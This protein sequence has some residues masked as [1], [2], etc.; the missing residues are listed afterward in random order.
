MFRA[1]DKCELLCYNY[2]EKGSARRWERKNGSFGRLG[3]CNRMTAVKKKTINMTEGPLLG[4]IIVFFLPLMATN[5]LQTL[6]NAADMMVVGM[7]S[8]PDAVG[9]I[10]LTGAFVNL[11]LNVFMGFATGANVVVARFLGARDD[12]RASRA[13]HTAIS[14]SVLLGVVGT[15]IGLVVSRPVLTLMGAEG[16]LL[17][18]ATTYT[19]IYFAGAPF[20]ALTNY[21]IAIL[22][23]KGDT[24][25]PLYVL[26]LSGLANVLMNLFFVL[27]L[28]FSV[29]GVA[30]ATV[31]SNVLSAAL[32]LGKLSRD[33]GACR[34]SFRRLC[35][36]RPA[37]R[38]IIYIGLPAGVQGSLFS[39][40]NM[41]IQSSILQV[42]NMTVGTETA[43]A[44]IV[45]GNAAAGN[46]EG[47]AY[48]ATNSLYQAAITFTSQNVGAAKY[49]R[50]HK[51]MA[52]CYFLTFCVAVIFSGTLF[53]LRTPL[54]ALYDVHPDVVGSLEHIAYETA[55]TKMNIMFTLYFF[56]AFMEVGCGVIRGLGLSVTSAVI[57]L[58]GACAFR[59]VWIMTVFRAFPT[60]E[61]IY[62]SYPISWGM[63]ALASFTVAMVRL[64]HYLK[65]RKTKEELL[66][67]D[68]HK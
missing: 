40:S 10:G 56:L 37:L 47:F 51:V 7:S 24:K 22:R 30:L 60:L 9:A 5:L 21:C 66:A 43:F 23:A 26:S 50:V 13:T 42:N 12:E 35:I 52:C 63:T 49:E 11:V 2:V 65:T 33:E 32:L 15:A 41:V 61:I 53:L 58:L 36:D 64:R 62:W 39:I 44:P 59:V 48:T 45:K 34:F 68:W 8:E 57:T 1:L 25:T 31:F 38:Q 20:L 67:A 46:L 6:Y 29:E 55:V 14:L 54:L 19:L 17:D 16:K 28:K 4:K 3:W 18:L 27:V